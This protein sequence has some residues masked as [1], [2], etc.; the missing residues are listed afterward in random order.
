MFDPPPDDV[1]GENAVVWAV[2]N[3]NSLRSV[4]S[5]STLPRRGED[6]QDDCKRSDLDTY[7]DSFFRPK[8]VDGFSPGLN[9]PGTVL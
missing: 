3:L 1:C 9:L 2:N 5:C 7:P 8:I 4:R 6:M